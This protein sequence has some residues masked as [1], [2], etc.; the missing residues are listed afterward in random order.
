MSLFSMPDMDVWNQDK[1]F[2]AQQWPVPEVDFKEN[3]KIRRQKRSTLVGRHYNTAA[4]HISIKRF[5]HLI[6]FRNWQIWQAVR[7]AAAL[8]QQKYQLLSC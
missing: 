2:I 5:S 4:T 1:N 8:N 6:L 7:L 3:P